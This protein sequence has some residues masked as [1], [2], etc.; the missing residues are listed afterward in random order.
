MKSLFAIFAL[1]LILPIY[2]SPRGGAR[3][4]AFITAAP[5]SGGVSITNTTA[6]LVNWWKMDEN[7]G[8]TAAD[9]SGSITGS[10]AAGTPTWAV[11]QINSCLDF[12]SGGFVQLNANTGLGGVVTPFT[13]SVWVNR[14]T[15]GGDIIYDYGDSGGGID[16]VLSGGSP[17]VYLQG[18]SSDLQ[19]FAGVS[20]ALG[21]WTHITV[22]YDGGFPTATSVQIYT[23]AVVAPSY[24]H[25]QNGVGDGGANTD[26]HRGIG[27]N[28]STANFD[29]KI[30]DVRIWNRVLT[31]GEIT[32]M[33]QWS[34]QP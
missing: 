3:L 14:G 7:T 19:R 5:A 20:I 8:T 6:G 25:S 22:T 18:T 33:F 26:T 2:A 12:S 4:T 23:N 28:R 31:A 9:S 17:Q 27:N 30:D 13:V 34:G 24:S 15:S 21:T 10:F 29:G 16:F 11:G 32:N 1:A